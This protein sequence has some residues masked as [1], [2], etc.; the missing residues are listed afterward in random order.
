MLPHFFQPLAFTDRKLIH[1]KARSGN[2]GTAIVLVLVQGES[3]RGDGRGGVRIKVLLFELGHATG[4]GFKQ[5]HFLSGH[6]FDVPL[7]VVRIGRRPFLEERVNVLTC[8]VLVWW[9]GFNL[10]SVFGQGLP[11]FLFFAWI[12][13]QQH[14]ASLGKDGHV[15]NLD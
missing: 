9:P 5:L 14:H 2:H 6:G 4:R 7:G 3:Q 15:W 13:G 12:A 11:D 10:P 8:G 1:N